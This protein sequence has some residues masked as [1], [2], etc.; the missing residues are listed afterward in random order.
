M[1]VDN[2]N[3]IRLRAPEFFRLHHLSLILMRRRSVG[4]QSRA[5]KVHVLVRTLSHA[6]MP[7]C[8]NSTAENAPMSRSLNVHGHN[9]DSTKI[10]DYEQHRLAS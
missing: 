3:Q 6:R 4:F 9:L 7:Y 2:L 10:T 1:T 8:C 5:R